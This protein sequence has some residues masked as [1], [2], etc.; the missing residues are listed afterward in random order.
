MLGSL[1][2]GFYK[3]EFPVKKEGGKPMPAK[4]KAAKKA[5]KKKKR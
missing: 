3:G 1:G 4:K 5:A 2:Q